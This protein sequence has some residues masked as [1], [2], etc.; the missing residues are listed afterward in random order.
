MSCS[1]PDGSGAGLASLTDH[2]RLVSRFALDFLTHLRTRLSLGSDSF[3]KRLNVRVDLLN[4][5][6]VLGNDA[7][8]LGSGYFFCK[9][10]QELIPINDGCFLVK[11]C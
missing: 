1:A 7:F 5:W 8:T 6:R 2:W 11:V 9:P 4:L 10:I 3:L